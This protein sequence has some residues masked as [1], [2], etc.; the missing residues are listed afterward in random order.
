MSEI[1]CQRC[2]RKIQERIVAT[3]NP[4]KLRAES[5]TLAYHLADGQV[6][7][8]RCLATIAAERYPELMEARQ[9]AR[10]AEP[11][12]PD[13]LPP[14]GWVWRRC[15]MVRQA[16]L[17]EWREEASYALRKRIE[18]P[19]RPEPCRVPM[20]V[21]RTDYDQRCPNTPRCPGLVNPKPPKPD[22]VVAT[23]APSVRR[24]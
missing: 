19:P 18:A 5:R 12:I 20:L 9:D 23:R 4:A 13:F 21:R 11:P 24:R 1:K 2:P 15:E 6:V 14:D 17:D 8:R 7:C 22:G 10:P 3:T 16:A